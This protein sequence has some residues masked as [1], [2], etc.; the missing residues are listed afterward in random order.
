M[1][2]YFW[3][4]HFQ[5]ILEDF[6]QENPNSCADPVKRKQMCELL[7][8]DYQRL[9]VWLVFVSILLEIKQ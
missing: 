4:E 6:Y 1:K 2:E 9:K 3:M 7:S 5:Q 8:I